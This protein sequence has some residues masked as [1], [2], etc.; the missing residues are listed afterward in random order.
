M[1]IDTHMHM[2]MHMHMHIHTH[3]RMRMHTC[4]HM[5]M[6]MRMHRMGRSQI[7]GAAAGS[8]E[9]Y[10]GLVRGKHTRGW[11]C[12]REPLWYGVGMV[13]DADGGMR[14]GS[15]SKAGAML[16]KNT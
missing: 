5:H 3:M 2:H 7:K 16:S 6:H 15:A 8:C 4:M 1:H 14:M 10:S 9:A 11:G 13:G 12:A